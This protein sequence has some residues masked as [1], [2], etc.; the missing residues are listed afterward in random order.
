MSEETTEI[1]SDANANPSASADAPETKLAP[2]EKTES[3]KSA[4]IPRKSWR[5]QCYFSQP[6]APIIDYKD[7]KLL[8]R[9]LTERGKI[10]PN[11]L[12]TVSIQK[13]RDLANAVKRA[14]AIALLPYVKR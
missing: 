9:F 11:R 5:K 7:T 2:G 6:G 13:Q 1:S 14:R 4:S 3:A 8:Q 12:S 10:V